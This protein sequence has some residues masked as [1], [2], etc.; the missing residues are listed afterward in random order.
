M[1]GI[2]FY[3]K[4]ASGYV[5]PGLGEKYREVYKKS[6]ENAEEY[7]SRIALEA[8]YWKRLWTKYTDGEPPFQRFF[9][10]G[11]TNWTYLIDLDYKGWRRNKILYYWE[12]EGGSRRIVSL[13]SFY[14]MVNRYSYALAKLGLRKG[15]RVV[16]YSSTTPEV[17]ALM[18]AINRIGGI[19]VPVSPGL[20]VEAL[21]QRI[22]DSKARF[23]VTADGIRRRGKILP[24]SQMV[25]KSIERASGVERV[26]VVKRLGLSDLG[27]EK[28]IGVWLDD[29][30]IEVPDNVYVE[31]VWLEAN[32]P[33]SI[34]YTSGTSGRPKG[35]VHSHASAI[36][37]VYSL[38]KLIFGV[39]DKGAD[40]DTLFNI[41][42]LGWST[43]VVAHVIG[44]HM[45]K[46][47]DVMYDGA[48][49]YPYPDQYLR[50]IERYGV[51]I[52]W[53]VPTVFRML[54]FLGDEQ[55]MKR[56]LT[57][58]RLILSIGERFPADLWSWTYKVLGRGRIPVVDIYGSTESLAMASI[59]TGIE[60][61]PI[62]PG[63]AGVVMPGFEIDI[64]DED[65][66]SLGKNRLGLIALRVPFKAPYA[67]VTVWGDADNF[68]KEGWKG[69]V[70][71]LMATYYRIPGYYLVGD[72]GYLD[73]DG[74]LWVVGR[75]DD[76]LKIAGHRITSEEIEEAIAKHPAVAEVMVVGKPDAVK[77]ETAVAFV[78]LR[79][80]FQGTPE[81]ANEL[82]TL[83]REKVG[84][85]AVIDAIYFVPRLPKNRSGK[86]VRRVGK[87]LA[88]SQPAGD[89]SVLEDPSVVEQL[90]KI[91]ELNKY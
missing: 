13:G 41:S 77:G 88:S 69:D 71:K 22:A 31:P 17:A 38:L 34:L 76:T 27:V 43:G 23:I 68:G 29:I 44:P 5:F 66:R 14:I 81:L 46:Y 19:T 87:A 90:K 32:E 24:L 52:F 4:E 11:L 20:A 7:Y 33:I 85:I 57:S 51:T 26:I 74:Y 3:Y 8:L 1:S 67:F 10:G 2:N 15:D 79:E 49:D 75:A 28:D 78:V 61:L 21:S 60:T 42:E 63:S 9:V 6:I 55:V 45:F 82:R 12:D 25:G 56:D 70:D 89:L 36:V 16:I 59:P 50:L 39:P 47:A 73:D 37:G 64:I 72:A 18:A 30:M 48:P 53:A 54:R 80:G 40:A 65:G 84:P 58:L 83:V 35:I 91:M 62:K 86:L